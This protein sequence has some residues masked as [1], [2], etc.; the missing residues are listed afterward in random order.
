MRIY[1]NQLQANLNK[2]LAPLWLIFGDEP[3]QKI[4]SLQRLKQNAKTQGFEELIRFS[5]DPQ[6]DWQQVLDELN[7]LS[8]FASRRIIEVDLG[9]GKVDEKAS[10]ALIQLSEHF[11][12]NQYDDL[13]V[14]IH[15]KKLDGA[16]T[17]KK[18]FKTLDKTATYLPLYELEGNSLNQW[19][20]QRIKH[21][22]LT[23]D[24]QASQLLI[25]FFEGNLPA[26]DQE[27]EKLTILFEQKAIATE[28]LASLLTKQAKFNPYQLVDNLLNGQLDK[29][30]SI[31]NQQQH[32]GLAPAQLI[33]I[34]HKEINQL[35]AMQGALSQGQSKNELYQHYRI[36][37]KRKP[38]YNHALA[39]ISSTNLKIALKR[40]SQ[41]DLIS[42]SSSEFNVFIL[43]ADVC[44]SLYYGER[45]SA[46]DLNLEYYG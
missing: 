2:A 3:W 37:D 44:S 20:Y 42:K 36:W 25:D 28:Q 12:N 13:L 34:L 24:P 5:C 32:E 19:L 7:S 9:E 46:F 29:A 14:I 40:L 45:T 43:L 27:L 22:Q 1:H 6:F 10:K 16:A 4:D 15:G 18:W 11:T 38:L 26:L 17:R 33:W 30:L 21:Y 39:N 8:L 35:L 41:T 23:L 31:L